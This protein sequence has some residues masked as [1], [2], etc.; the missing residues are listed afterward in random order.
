MSR[1]PR[2]RVALR[3]GELRRR[4]RE[5]NYRYYVL[6]RPT[7]SVAAYH[8]LF[9]ELQALERRHPELV[10]PDSPTQRVGAAPAEAFA[11]VRHATPMLS[12]DDAFSEEQL[13]AFDRRVRERLAIEEVEYAAEPS[14]TA[15]RSASSTS[16]AFSSA[17]RPGATASRART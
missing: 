3:I 11:S 1:E 15:S 8:R 7:I 14:S 17:A 13:A 9:R 2:G 5:H 16:G 10:S 6:D 12:M 4:I